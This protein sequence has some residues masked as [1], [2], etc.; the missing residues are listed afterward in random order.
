MAQEIYDLLSEEE[1]AQ[2]IEQAKEEHNMAMEKWKDDTEAQY[3]TTPPLISL[4]SGGL[5]WT[6]RWTPLD[7][8]DTPTGMTMD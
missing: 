1:K 2:W 3:F 5:H 8:G 4:D 6:L 7:S